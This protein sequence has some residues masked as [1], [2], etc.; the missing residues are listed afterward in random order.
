[1]IYS[2]AMKCADRLDGWIADIKLKLSKYPPGEM[3]VSRNGKYFKWSFK[4]NEGAKPVNIAKKNKAFAEKFKSLF[5]TDKEKLKNYSKI[6]YAQARLISGLSLENPAEVS[7]L[8][9]DLMAQ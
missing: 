6:L 3:Y 1:M 9:C 2:K 8:V 4:E 7:N 5:E